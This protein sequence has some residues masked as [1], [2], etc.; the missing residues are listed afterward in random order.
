MGMVKRC[1]GHQARRSELFEV[2]VICQQQLCGMAVGEGDAAQ[3]CSIDFIEASP[4][5]HA[6]GGQ[7]TDICVQTAVAYTKLLGRPELRVNRPSQ[8]LANK[9]IGLGL[10]FCIVNPPGQAQYAALAV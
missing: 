4:E 9:L 8:T 10:G 7:I 6:L 5:L 3:F 2:A 1:P